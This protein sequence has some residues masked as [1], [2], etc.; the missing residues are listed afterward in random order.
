M[1][2]FSVTFNNSFFSNRIGPVSPKKK[3][4]IEW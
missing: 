3:Q 2:E 4:L 1:V